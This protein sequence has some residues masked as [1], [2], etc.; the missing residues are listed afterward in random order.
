MKDA[1]VFYYLEAWIGSSTDSSVTRYLEQI[2]LF[3]RQLTTA[4]FRLAG[5]VEVSS[6]SSLVK[7]SKQHPIPQT[8]VSKI[9]KAF[10]DSLYALLDGLVLL[11]SDAS[12]IVTGKRLITD[13]SLSM[14]PNSLELLDLTD[15]VCVHSSVLLSALRKCTGYPNFSSDL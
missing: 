11:A 8:F 7:S 10:M 3:Q 6:S 4:A 1:R 5:G 14:G 2:E 9:V 13:T 15:N 12:P